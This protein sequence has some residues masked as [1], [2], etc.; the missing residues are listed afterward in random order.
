MT[1]VGVDKY[2]KQR[3]R[4]QSDL[5]AMLECVNYAIYLKQ[6]TLCRK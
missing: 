2:Q 1:T 6:K 5:I 4:L 3:I